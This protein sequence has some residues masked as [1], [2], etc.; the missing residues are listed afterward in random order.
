MA[1]GN[2]RRSVKSAGR[3]TANF[4][5]MVGVSQT[6]PRNTEGMI[7]R[8]GPGFDHARTTKSRLSPRAIRGIRP[9]GFQPPNYSTPEF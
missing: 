7:M 6:M 3:S 8:A 9:P 2:H 5:G 1:R 4:G